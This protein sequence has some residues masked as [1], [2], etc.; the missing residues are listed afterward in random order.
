MFYEI[1][2]LSA[3]FIV[4]VIIITGATTNSVTKGLVF[5]VKDLKI[6]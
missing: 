1:V 3:F 6:Y 2:V 4:L 5:D